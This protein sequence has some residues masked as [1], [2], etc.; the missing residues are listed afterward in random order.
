MRVDRTFNGEY[1]AVVELGADQ[2]MPLNAGNAFRYARAVAAVAQRTEYDA[3]MLRQ[4]IH[5]LKLGK[6]EALQMVQ[7]IRAARDPIDEDALGLLHLEPGVTENLRGSGLRPFLTVM[8]NGRPLGEWSI[9]EA[10][11]HAL[12]VLETVEATEL[13]AGYWRFLTGRIGAEDV[14]AAYMVANIARWR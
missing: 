2:S 7:E 3:A 14:P 10:R 13:D 12:A 6:T 1:V 4:M 5:H 8:A 11:S 9:E